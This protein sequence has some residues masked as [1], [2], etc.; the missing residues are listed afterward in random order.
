MANF[1]GVVSDNVADDARPP[2]ICTCAANEGW[3]AELLVTVQTIIEAPTIDIVVSFAKDKHFQ[4]RVHTRVVIAHNVLDPTLRASGC[5]PHG[6]VTYFYLLS[7]EES[8]GAASRRSLRKGISSG[9]VDSNIFNRA[10][11]TARAALSDL[12]P[13]RV[14]LRRVGVR[15]KFLAGKSANLWRTIKPEG[16][17]SP[18]H[19]IIF[20]SSTDEQNRE[21]EGGNQ[22][23]HG[24]QNR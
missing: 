21:E 12:R 5:E 16:R 10:A 22:T 13:G 17:R 3:S 9:R 6:L 18:P 19:V 1:C 14:C 23:Q 7:P 24:H 2:P 4:A 8:L 20:D 11:S 15:G